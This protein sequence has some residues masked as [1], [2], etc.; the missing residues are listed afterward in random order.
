M[1]DSQRVIFL[2]KGMGNLSDGREWKKDSKIFL[3]IPVKK[4]LRLEPTNLV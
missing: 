1:I 2:L 3:K 4:F